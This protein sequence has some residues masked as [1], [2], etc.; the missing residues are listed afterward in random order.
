MRSSSFHNNAKAD[1]RQAERYRRRLNARG[2]SLA[3]MQ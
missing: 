1:N 3:M 2:P